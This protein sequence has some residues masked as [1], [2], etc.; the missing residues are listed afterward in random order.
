VEFHKYGLELV[1][2]F[3]NAISPPEEVQKAIDARSSMGA[4][5]DL[6]AYTV[7][8]AANSLGK[9]AENQGAAGGMGQGAMGMGMGAGFGMM[10]P[11]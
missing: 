7:F 3:I 10:L 5:G 4:I 6:Q 8:Q 2:L 1:E 9:L 11:G